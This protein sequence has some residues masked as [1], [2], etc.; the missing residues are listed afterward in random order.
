MSII[1]SYLV[2][3][4]NA[5]LKSGESDPV[6]LTSFLHP[7]RMTPIPFRVL[8]TTPDAG[9]SKLEIML[10][11]ADSRDGVYE[12]VPNACLAFEQADLASGKPLVW[13]FLPSQAS[14]PWLRLEYAVTGGSGSGR[15]FAALLREEELPYETGMYIDKGVVEG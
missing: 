3:S 12:D 11:Q 9:V 4:D 14:K 8:I 1:D 2:F 7:G 15:I 13:R 10:Q 6:G 5:E